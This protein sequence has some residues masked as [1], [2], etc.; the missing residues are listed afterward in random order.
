M[1]LLIAPPLP[2]QR[3]VVETLLLLKELGRNLQDES[4]EEQQ[5]TFRCLFITV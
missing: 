4:S 3:S 5:Q 2:V 1:E